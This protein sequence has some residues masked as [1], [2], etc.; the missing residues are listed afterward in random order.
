MQARSYIGTLNNPE[1]SL[2]VYF[3]RFMTKAR[4][5]VGQK[6]VGENGT[7]H[8][9]FYVN[10]KQP[11]RLAALKKICSKAHFEKCNSDGASIAY[12]QKEETRVEG[13]V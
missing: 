1:E 4:F 7:P 10:F 9:Q 11:V 6:E 13:P 5:I 12:V 2:E 3:K 8:Y